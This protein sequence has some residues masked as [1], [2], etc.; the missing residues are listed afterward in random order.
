M[1][2]GPL[3]SGGADTLLGGAWV[4]QTISLRIRCPFSPPLQKMVEVD[5]PGTTDDTPDERMTLVI[6]YMGGKQMKVSAHPRTS[7]LM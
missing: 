2:Q 4:F 3:D 6:V 5:L 7:S 1:Y